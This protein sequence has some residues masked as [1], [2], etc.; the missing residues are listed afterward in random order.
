MIRFNL[1]KKTIVILMCAILA[2]C[3]GGGGGGGGSG[4]GAPSTTPSAHININAPKGVFAGELLS[5]IGESNQGPH[6]Y[7]WDFGDGKK[8]TDAAPSHSYASEG[9]YTVTLAITN[10]AGL[11]AQSSSKISILPAKVT[12][13]ITG[14]STN[15]LTIGDSIELEAIGTG[16]LPINYEWDFGDGSIIQGKKVIHAYSKAGSYQITL[17]A[18]DKNG[19]T[20]TSQASVNVATSKPTAQLVIQN[21]GQITSG[22][23]VSLKAY[24]SGYRSV[25]FSWEFGDGEKGDGDFQTHTY[26]KAGTYLARVTVTD[27]A[28][29]IATA[30]TT[31]Q[32]VSPPSPII[33]SM[34]PS[35]LSILAGEFI[36]FDMIVTGEGNLDYAW[37]FGDGSSLVKEKSPTHH[38]PSSGTF[39]VTAYAYSSN[40]Q[41]TQA[42]A[43]ISVARSGM[44]VLAGSIF[45]P[46]NLDGNGTNARF[47]SPGKVSSS[48]D[49]YLFLIDTV[50]TVNDLGGRVEQKSIRRIDK[51]GNV[52][53]ILSGENFASVSAGEN[54]GFYYLNGDYIPGGRVTIYKVSPAN[55]KSV[56]LSPDNGDIYQ[57]LSNGNGKLYAL[58]DIG[59]YE[60]TERNGWSKT[61]TTSAY[62]RDLEQI[63]SLGRLYFG[64]SDSYYR[65]D[66]NKK[67]ELLRK[68]NT[69]SA[70]IDSDG[71][72][73]DVHYYTHDIEKVTPS[74]ESSTIIRGEADLNLTD[75][76][77]ADPL[78]TM[79]SDGSVYI[80]NS[81]NA[82]IQKRDL[83]GHLSIVAG[84][85]RIENRMQD[86]CGDAILAKPF[87]LSAGLDGEKIFVDHSFIRSIESN[88]CVK[89]LYTPSD[90]DKIT[91]LLKSQSGAI[92]FTTTNKNGV[93]KLVN[94]KAEVF[95]QDVYR[96]GDVQGLTEDAAGN[97]YLIDTTGIHKLSASG[98]KTTIFSQRSFPIPDN[99]IIGADIAISPAGEIFMASNAVFRLNTST[100]QME[101]I[102]SQAQFKKARG[103]AIDK[104]GN[105][106][107]ADTGNAVIR[108]ISPD[109][110]V[111]IVAGQLGK[112]G[113][114]A[115]ALPATL[116][117]PRDVAIDPRNGHLLVSDT[118]A[119]LE[120]SID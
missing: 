38:F 91:G 72:I 10:Q 15:A 104:A 22:Q 60:Y 32:V 41:Q 42:T 33:Y 107:V 2:A 52:V 39:T 40:G 81:K 49:G 14:L 74:G 37:D 114:L 58:L 66:S 6:T 27:E 108:K 24:G 78:L 19:N 109:G 86:S 35:N 45:G 8:S 7:E 75:P 71:N 26:K 63:D 36:R 115:G 57:I 79:E 100:Q 101:A 120:I 83:Q 103:I 119:I 95:Y 76:L 93:F 67:L 29:E 90:Y 54:G 18:K 77:D 25:R 102:S 88:G 118:G 85:Y 113:T 61:P 44:R 28:G 97:I 89:S 111:S 16:S 55:V 46:G 84:G 53:T 30:A 105:I 64:S 11:R 4:G 98:A 31:I 62:P 3:G 68:K 99:D 116:T 96:Y 117:A 21:T 92:Y 94:G 13:T 50:T 5:F 1:I 34:N 59:L 17:K 80:V 87:M 9:S 43:T 47:T 51:M 20:S 65:I 56:I 23:A 106:F 82:T 112:K 110:S 12:A 48:I 70:G 69:F 73:Y